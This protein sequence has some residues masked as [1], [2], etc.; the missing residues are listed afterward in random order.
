MAAQFNPLDQALSGLSVADE[1]K[2]E[3]DEVLGQIIEAS[4]RSMS[5]LKNEPASPH[6]VPKRVII[7]SPISSDPDEDARLYREYVERVTRREQRFHPFPSMGKGSDP[8]DSLAFSPPIVEVSNHTATEPAVST[9]L[10]PDSR[11]EEPQMVEN[12]DRI[13]EPRPV[14]SVEFRWNPDELFVLDS[15]VVVSPPDEEDREPAESFK[16]PLLNLRSG[17]RSV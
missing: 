3:A 5:P 10:S 12:G 2:K 15:P 1:S 8:S 11:E 4:C 14:H 16:P 7:W 17:T 13:Q 9:F 6:D